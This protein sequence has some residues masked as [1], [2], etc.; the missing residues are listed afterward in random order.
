MQNIYSCN[1]NRIVIICP[2]I[3]FRIV[4]EGGLKMVVVGGLVQL[5]Q[6][7]KRRDS[8]SQATN[9]QQSPMKHACFSLVAAKYPMATRAKSTVKYGSDL[10]FV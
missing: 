2:T 4:A 10:T 1:C 6:I 9:L 3:S 7:T 5:A 8:S